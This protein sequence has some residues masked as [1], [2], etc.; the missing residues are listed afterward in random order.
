MS[1]EQ[2][3]LVFRH[4]IIDPNTLGTKND[5][6]LVGDINGNGAGDA[7][8]CY[9]D[10]SNDGMVT[11]PDIG[12]LSAEYGRSDC[13]TNPCLADANGDGAVNGTDLGILS[14]EYGRNDCPVIE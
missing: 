14:A 9:A 4:R 13:D 12:I 1:N 7:C 6:C 11:G 10:F 8:E 2:K 3:P 5:V